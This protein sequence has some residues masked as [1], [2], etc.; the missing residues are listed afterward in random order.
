MSLRERLPIGAG[1]SAFSSIWRV[2]SRDTD[3]APHRISRNTTNLTV[4]D[5]AGLGMETKVRCAAKLEKDHFTV[6]ALAGIWRS[7][8]FCF[9]VDAS[10]RCATATGN[11]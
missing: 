2:V 5:P 10:E 7:V 11:I 4:N 3:R 1:G 9:A 6:P 8:A